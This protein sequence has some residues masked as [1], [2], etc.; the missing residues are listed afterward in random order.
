MLKQIFQEQVFL[1]I[2]IL[3]QKFKRMCEIFQALHHNILQ[4]LKQLF[5][6]MDRKN[7]FLEQVF[8][9]Q[10]LQEQ[11]FQEQKFQENMRRICAEF[12]A[13]HHSTLQTF[14]AYMIM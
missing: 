12:Q 14:I 10:V 5:Q 11:K 4:M 9:E 7:S 13:I 1:R 6:V 2:N 8:Q 3:Q